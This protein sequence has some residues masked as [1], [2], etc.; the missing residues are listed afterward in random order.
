[1][2]TKEDEDEIMEVNEEASGPEMPDDE[3]TSDAETED[4]EPPEFDGQVRI[5]GV[6]FDA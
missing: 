1:M 2:L 4:Q 3:K 5:E 6:A